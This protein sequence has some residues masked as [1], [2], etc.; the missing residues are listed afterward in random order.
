MIGSIA[1]EAFRQLLFWFR[2]SPG[3]AEELAESA[4]QAKASRQAESSARAIAGIRS[5]EFEVEMG[6]GD[7]FSDMSDDEDEANE[8]QSEVNAAAT[9]EPEPVQSE[10]GAREPG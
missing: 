6:T 10:E 9:T 7:S 4:V 1:G 2:L 8:A 3:E 5:G